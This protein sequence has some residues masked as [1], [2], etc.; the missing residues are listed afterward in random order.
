[1]GAP[2]AACARNCRAHLFSA[3][4]DASVPDLKD[5]IAVGIAGDET[6]GLAKDTGKS[7][8]SLNFCAFGRFLATARHP[9]D[10]VA[11]GHLDDSGL[12]KG[13]ENLLDITQEGS[14]RSN[15]QYSRTLKAFAL[16]VEQVGCA[17]KSNGSF[18]GSRS[19]LDDEDSTV[20]CSDDSVLLALN[21]CDDIA[22]SSASCRGKS[23][24]QC[25]FALQS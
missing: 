17:V 2:A 19:S 21:R 18:S 5:L 4:G 6:H 12:S 13:G 16:G 10:E 24:H 14:R 3:Q 9:R 15:D 22:H 25:S 20:T 7:G 23:R 11:D 8:T 1:M